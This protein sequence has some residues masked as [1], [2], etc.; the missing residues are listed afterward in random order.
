MYPHLSYYSAVGPEACTEDWGGV[1]RGRSGQLGYNG[2]SAG[3]RGGA[4]A[5]EA[6]LVQPVMARAVALVTNKLGVAEERKLQDST[7]AANLQDDALNPLGRS[8]GKRA[9]F[10]KK[11][12]SFQGEVKLS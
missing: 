2:A 6:S 8:A 11:Q 9:E 4:A 3:T 12:N 10:R 7:K 1:A 5:G